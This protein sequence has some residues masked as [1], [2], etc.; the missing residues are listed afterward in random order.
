[1]RIISK[2]KDYY[3]YLQGIYGVDEKLIL[4][5]TE[6]FPTPDRFRTEVLRYKH[7]LDS[8][9]L[10]RFWICGYLIEGLYNEG[11][12]RFFYGN[13]L[14]DLASNDKKQGKGKFSYY[15]NQ[16][17]ADD[18]DFY[19][20]INFPEKRGWTKVAKNPITFEDYYRLQR[21][22]FK[23]IK[24]EICPNDEFNCPILYDAGLNNPDYMKFPVLSDFELHKVYSAHDLWILLT[25][26]LGREKIIPNKQ[27]NKEKIQSNGF[28]L[29][30][31]FRHP[32]K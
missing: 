25:E 22:P 1:M 27:T 3:D 30:T 15:I 18:I 4:D 6:F 20:Y 21:G 12:G 19:W 5:R 14:R 26:W 29:K 11:S 28:D 9:E 2:Y 23:D 8:Y 10:V 13:E 32:I 24:K 31:S 17:H 7:N 16:H